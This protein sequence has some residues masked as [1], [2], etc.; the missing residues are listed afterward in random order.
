ME[1]A[2][3]LWKF[4]TCFINIYSPL[5]LPRTNRDSSLFKNTNWQDPAI[6]SKNFREKCS[7][8]KNKLFKS[9]CIKG[10][11]SLKAS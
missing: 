11:C 3:R 1:E 6:I 2:K 10:T 8:W 9:P 7:S 4:L 5:T